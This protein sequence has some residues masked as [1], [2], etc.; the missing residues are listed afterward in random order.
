MLP[1]RHL[2]AYTGAGWLVAFC[3]D[4]LTMP[5][6]SADPAAAHMDVD[7]NGRTVGLW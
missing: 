1:I 7:E 5:G 6:L 4:V 2:S 3:G